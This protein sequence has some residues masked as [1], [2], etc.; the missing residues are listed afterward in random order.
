MRTVTQPE[1]SRAAGRPRRTQQE[2]RAATERRILD[3]AVHL[4]ASSGSSAVSLADVGEAAGYS[5]GIVTHQFGTRDEMLRQVVRY[6][7][8]SFVPPETD[9][10]GL[11]LLLVTVDAYLGYLMAETPAGRAFLLMWGEA[12]APDS[13]LRPIFAERDAWFRDL[14]RDYIGEG[15][16]EGSIRA[17]TDPDAAAMAVMSQLRGIGLELMISPSAPRA[18]T[19]RA[20][21]VAM[22]RRALQAR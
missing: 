18:E 3:A 8:Q 1:T 17:G 20:E 22:V 4:I 16:R 14:L 13:S 19:V 10:R 21:T 15:V 2:R 6:A 11:E 9:A 12:A 5:R 7:Q